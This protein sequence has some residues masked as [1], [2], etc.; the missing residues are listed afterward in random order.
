MFRSGVDDRCPI[1]DAHTHM[2]RLLCAGTRSATVH[3]EITTGAEQAERISGTL[4][5][6]HGGWIQLA[7]L[8]FAGHRVQRERGKRR[9]EARSG[10]PAI[11]GARANQQRRSRR[12]LQT[13]ERERA[14]E[15]KTRSAAALNA[16]RCS[17]LEDASRSPVLGHALPLSSAM[18]L[19]DTS[20]KQRWRIR[21]LLIC[22][23]A[24]AGVTSAAA[25]LAGT[26]VGAGSDDRC[27]RARAHEDHTRRSW[28][29]VACAMARRGRGRR[30]FG[31]TQRRAPC[32]ACAACAVWRCV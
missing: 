30:F 16:A 18:S 5:A 1:L 11:S 21:S 6:T 22:S 31:Q 4:R 13:R 15:I 32:C 14:G 27:A 26:V 23:S 8:A 9:G 20:S 25:L 7:Q 2:T 28:V 10:Q 19:N 17:L 29:S 24:S 12:N 3:V